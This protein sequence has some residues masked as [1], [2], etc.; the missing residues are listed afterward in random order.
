MEFW[1]STHPPGDKCCSGCTTHAPLSHLAA[2]SGLIV[3]CDSMVGAKSDVDDM[4][5]SS[6]TSTW[7]Y[8]GKEFDADTDVAQNIWRVGSPILLVVGLL[9]NALSGLV[10]R[11]KKMQSSVTSLYLLVLAFSDSSVLLI[12][13]VYNWLTYGYQQDIQ[14]YSTFTCKVHKTLMFFCIHFEAWVLVSVTLE[15]LA[16]VA[17]PFRA[18]A[19]FTRA[20][21]RIGLVITALVLLLVNSHFMWDTHLDTSPQDSITSKCTYKPVYGGYCGMYSS[22]WS[23]V[24]LLISSLLPFASMLVMNIV[25]IYKLYRSCQF[26]RSH[27]EPIKVPSGR[28]SVRFDPN[29]HGG[30]S[31]SSARPMAILLLVVT[32]VFILLSAPICILILVGKQTLCKPEQRDSE[33]LQKLFVHFAI[34]NIVA[35]SNNSINFFLYFLSGRRFRTELTKMLCSCYKKS[36]ESILLADVADRH[37][38][39]QK[40][41]LT[42]KASPSPGP[43]PKVVVT[44]WQAT[45]H[46][47]TPD[48][49]PETNLQ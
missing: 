28:T 22:S 24:D 31:V 13:L 20:R 40:H 39:T 47:G 49:P 33:T 32:F 23:M 42:L 5:S 4:F 26:R 35:Y 7:S 17:F 29:T 10:M 15:R 30:H 18:K 11:R 2:A 34:V 45:A 6:N 27:S 16:A 14:N 44:Q 37:L 8:N 38:L 36:T 12:A 3:V 43:Q 19:C 25:I 48:N 1:E 9:G 21:A 41:T 46:P